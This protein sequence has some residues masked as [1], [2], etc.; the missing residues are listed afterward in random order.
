MYDALTDVG[1]VLDAT[2]T[3]R[4]FRE[5]IA[6]SMKVN[7]RVVDGTIDLGIPSNS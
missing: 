1:Q 2:S 5:N 4:R 6:E 7:E 3:D